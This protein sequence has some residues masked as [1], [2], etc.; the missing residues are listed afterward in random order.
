MLQQNQV[1]RTLLKYLLTNVY[2]IVGFGRVL[3]QANTVHVFHVRH[4]LS[5]SVD[6][7]NIV[8]IFIV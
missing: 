4:L 1:I 2:V 5:N 7:S 3:V 8:Y 6:A